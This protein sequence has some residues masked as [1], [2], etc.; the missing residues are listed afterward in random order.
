MI[1]KLIM[2][3]FHARTTA[4]VL[5]LRSRSYA[6]HVA[7]NTF[8]DE[9]I[10]LADTLAEPMVQPEPA[11]MP[12]AVV[13]PEVDEAPMALDVADENP[14]EDEPQGVGA[15][16]AALAA[17]TARV[18]SPTIEDDLP[19][20]PSAAALMAFSSRRQ[21]DEPTGKA[22]ALGAAKGTA[23]RPAV[24][25]PLA[26]A[27]E[28]AAV[29][30]PAAARPEPV[31]K[32]AKPGKS[33]LR[34][35]GA[36]VSPAAASVEKP[37]SKVSIPSALQPLKPADPATA[38]PARP[39]AARPPG[40]FAARPPVRGKPRYLGLVL[41]TVLLFLLAMIAA[42]SSYSLGAWN[43]GEDPVQTVQEDPAAP[44]TG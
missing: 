7:L 11:P 31:A 28:R 34:G 43:F 15:I 10:D 2:E 22:P 4:H 35:L 36:L 8:Y 33:A 14:V 5:H 20:P 38:A 41:T 40:G 23:S 12:P 18:I 25:K 42:W 21:G 27:A 9:I 44:D 13:L 39:A 32:P 16:K 26:A 1:G 24:A 37:R 30:R 6:Q 29:A 17:Q 3:L 19:P